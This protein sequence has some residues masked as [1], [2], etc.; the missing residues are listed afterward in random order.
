MNKY[1]R[2]YELLRPALQ[3]QRWW[4][5]HSKNPQLEICLGAILTQNTNWRNVEKALS[6][7]IKEDLIDAG[8]IKSI[9]TKTL[10]MLIKPSGCYNQKAKK[11][12]EFCGFAAGRYNGDMNTLFSL[13]AE[14]LRKKL[15]KING[16]GNETADSIMLYAAKKPVFVVDAY[17]KRIFSRLGLIKETEPYEEVQKK[18]MDHLPKNAA[19]FSS[20]HALLVEHG[21]QFC[22]KKP[23]CSSCPLKKVCNQTFK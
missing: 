16:V 17:T 18:F 4:P 2:I 22:R 1:L 10:S 19:L 9:S 8:K 11:L 3:K 23:L 6:S 20:F 14:E 5:T 21:K 15:L 12:K 7:L 13:S